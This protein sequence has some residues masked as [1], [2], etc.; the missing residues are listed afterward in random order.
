MLRG[1]AGKREHNPVLITSARDLFKVSELADTS[2]SVL[3]AKY[4]VSPILRA[5]NAKPF[6]EK[7][8]RPCVGAVA[9]G[10]IE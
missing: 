1:G 10:E 8:I 3:F 6:P 2:R 5:F 4:R 9:Q 7:R